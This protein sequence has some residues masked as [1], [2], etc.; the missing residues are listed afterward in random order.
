MNQIEVPWR[1]QL[2]LVG[3]GYAAVL[4]FAAAAITYRHLAALRNPAEFNGG[5]AAAGDWMLEIFIG[6]LL[7]IP[8]FFLALVIRK[9]EATY[10]AFSRVLFG[11]SLTA[12]ISL[13]LAMIP[14]IGQTDSMLGSLCLYRLCGLPMVMTWLGAGR[15][16]A[17]FKLAKRLLSWALA[18]EAMT[19]ALI[20][21]LLFFSG[22]A[23]RG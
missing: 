14:A 20:I 9:H 16:L 3:A 18:I 23:S 7:L 15:L 13:G 11:F 2:G 6:G 10:T 8:T 17:R 22:R 1:V 12:P 4:T 21:A 19:L 5:M